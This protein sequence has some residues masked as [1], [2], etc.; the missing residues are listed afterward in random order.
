MKKILLLFLLTIS[1]LF[2]ACSSVKDDEPGMIGYIVKVDNGRILVVDPEPKDFSSTG[3]ISEFYN[4]IWFSNAPKEVR[5][6]DKVK[7]WFDIVADS[8][9]GQSEALAV[10][11]IPSTK[12]EGANLTESEAL[13][14]ALESGNINV[15]TVKSIAFD[16]SN[17][18]NI[19]LYD[20]FEEKEFDI[21]VEDK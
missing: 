15:V 14:K 13:R 20:I 3:G 12:P 6:G 17:N 16:G 10:E 19:H 4:A 7:V 8:Y 18:W 1:F 9:P 2:V 11:V 21:V 5:P